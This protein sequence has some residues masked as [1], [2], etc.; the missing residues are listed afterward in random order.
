LHLLGFEQVRPVTDIRAALSVTKITAASNLLCCA[1]QCVS[2]VAP[3]GDERLRPLHGMT[4]ILSLS[5][6]R[7]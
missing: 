3:I 4:V 1:D 6:P 7:G 5:P 2:A